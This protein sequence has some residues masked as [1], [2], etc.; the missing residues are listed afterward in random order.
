[1]KQTKQTKRWVSLFL[2]LVLSIS[3]LLPGMPPVA[4][5]E[6]ASIKLSKTSMTLAVRQRTTLTVKGTKKKA[7]WTSS[8]SSVAAVKKGA[9]TAKKTGT[10]V[11][12]AKVGKRR[13]SCRV[14]VKGD[15]KTIYKQMLETGQVRYKSGSKTYMAAAK[16]FYVLDIDRNGVPELIVKDTEASNSFS[17][18]YVYTIRNGKAVYCGGYYQKGDSKLYYNSKYKSLYMWWWTNGVGGVGS[19]LYRLSGSQLKA[20]KYIWSGAKSYGSSKQVYYY[21]TNAKKGKSVSKK[22]YNAMF[23]KY[24]KSRKT[25]GFLN[26]TLTNRTKKFG[27]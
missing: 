11:I 12:T 21:G 4:K 27:K 6:A 17:T 2:I 15:Y 19:M 7:T 8:D 20:Y 18:R 14:T 23:K 13:L 16:S 1:M 24:F 9:V 25:F 5:V 10:A 3:T 26:N 22:T